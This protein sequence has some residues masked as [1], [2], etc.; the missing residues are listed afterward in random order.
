[1]TTACNIARNDAYDQNIVIDLEFTPVPNE[2]GPGCLHY[3]IIQIGAVRVSPAFRTPAARSQAGGV[4]V[5][6]FMDY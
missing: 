1:M 5:Q 4:V 6:C 2:A 3:E